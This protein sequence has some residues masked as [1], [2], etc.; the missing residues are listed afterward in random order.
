MILNTFQS[1]LQLT[2]PTNQTVL[3]PQYNADGTLNQARLLPQNAGFGAATAAQAPRTVQ[4]Q[5]R[6]QF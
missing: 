1:Q 5:L 4:V 3:N 6:F 2:S